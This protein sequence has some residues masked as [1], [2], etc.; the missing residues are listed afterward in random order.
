M[1]DKKKADNVGYVKTVQI[2]YKH[3]PCHFPEL[4]Y[5]QLWNFWHLLLF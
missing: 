4:S 5:S 3:K 2:K 1:E